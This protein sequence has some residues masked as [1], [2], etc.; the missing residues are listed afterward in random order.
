MRKIN[1]KAS[2]IRYSNLLTQEGQ[3]KVIRIASEKEKEE[4]EPRCLTWVSGTQ[5]LSPSST[6]FLVILA[7]N[8][9]GRKATGTQSRISI[10]LSDKQPLNFAP[11]LPLQ[12]L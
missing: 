9:F 11:M 7:G 3:W 8:C 2:G 1:K 6:T 10:W 12:N 5:A 4:Q